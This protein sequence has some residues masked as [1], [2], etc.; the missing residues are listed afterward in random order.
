MS[1]DGE[2]HELESLI[3]AASRMDAFPKI[4][5]TQRVMEQIRE[6]KP[7][8]KRLVWKLLS[9]TGAVAGLLT[10][11]LISV[12]AY[13]TSEFIQIRNTA[14]EVKV[15]Y[16]APERRPEPV[17]NNNFEQQALKKAKSG[18]LIAYYVKEAPT[19][20]SSNMGNKLQFAYKEKRW[21]SYSMFLQEMKRTGVPLLPE[22]VAD[23]PLE[24]GTVWPYLYPISQQL[25]TSPYYQKVLH[26]LITEAEGAKGQ[27]VF[28]QTVPWNEAAS[29]YGVYTLDTAHI[30]LSVNLLHGG[31]MT[32]YQ[33]PE[34]RTEPFQVEG[35]TVVYNDVDRK[36]VN[37]HYLSWYNEK[38]DAYFMLTTYGGHRLSK[39]ELLRLAGELIRSGL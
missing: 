34:N 16:A 13:A 15:Q 39:E 10:L 18:E 14:G 26:E 35:R 17:S 21:T 30:G 37:Y 27:R 31:D 25:S 9:P 1:R 38:Q 11:M 24:Y 36:E 5:V 28:S 7:G 2:R 20:A 3:Q 29:V 32:V 8:R 33:E 19:N 23:Y 4:E 12:T 6:E 22:T